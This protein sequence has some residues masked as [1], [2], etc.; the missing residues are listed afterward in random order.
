MKQIVSFRAKPW[1]DPS[2]L[3]APVK[4]D[5]SYPLFVAW[6][7]FVT[8]V[9][10]G[11]QNQCWAV[12]SWAGSTPVRFRQSLSINSSAYNNLFCP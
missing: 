7:R 11:L 8:G 6:K 12:M 4:L 5:R 2:R 10:L 1:V 3:S 9:A